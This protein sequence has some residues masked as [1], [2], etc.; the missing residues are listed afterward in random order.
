MK[1]LLFAFAA[2]CISALATTT[3][4]YSQYSNSNKMPDPAEAISR[5]DSIAPVAEN[6][7]IRS[8]INSRAL[9]SFS[10]SF[11][12]VADEKWTA[13]SEGFV[14]TF[15]TD[16]VRTFVYYNKKGAWAGSL[17][18]YNENKMNRSLRDIVKRRYYDFTITYV[19]EVET[20]DSDGKPTY[21]IHLGDEKNILLVRVN[22]GV[23][24]EWKKYNKQ[25]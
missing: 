22:D 17:K 7:N 25:K 5:L 8:S 24:E 18:G 14:A 11:K 9:K 21:V 12:N 19:D 23:M 20:I 3:G 16:D 10:K 6:V 2:G 4:V 1:K 15:K 13:T